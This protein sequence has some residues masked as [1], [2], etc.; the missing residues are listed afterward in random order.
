MAGD[1]LVALLKSSKLSVPQFSMVRSKLLCYG[2]WAEKL[3]LKIE[4]GDFESFNQYFCLDLGYHLT[5]TFFN[6][7]DNL[8]KRLWCDGI[9]GGYF[10]KKKV[11]DEREINTIAW[12]GEGGNNKFQMKIKL[13][14]YALRR[15][16]KGAAM[17]DCIPS[18]DSM[19][20]I[21]LDMIHKKIEVQLR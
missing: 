7:P 15:Y 21:N 19:E 5:S 18:A 20:W 8:I 12:I 2:E 10:S 6:S 14:K 13:G 16:A 11:N 3:I 4:N 9:I 17:V 1:A